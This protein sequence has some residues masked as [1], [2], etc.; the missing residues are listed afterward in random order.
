MIS[1][2][3][4]TTLAEALREYPG[5]VDFLVE[6]SP[7]YN[8]LKNT[9][10]RKLMAPRT[11]L[12]KVAQRGGLTFEELLTKLNAA[13]E[14]LKKGATQ[15]PQDDSEQVKEEIKSMIKQLKAGEDINTFKERFKDLLRKSNPLVIAVAEA[16]LTR[17]GYTIQDLMNACD[18]HLELF[19]ENLEKAKV[20]VP[21]EHPLWRLTRDHEAI[22]FWLNQGR[23][24]V[25]EMMKREGYHDSGDLVDKL[26]GIMAKLR[27]AENHDVRQENTLFPVLE[28][29]GVEEPAT[30]MWE[31]HS[32]MKDRRRE[33]GRILEAPP[34]G[35]D[36]RKYAEYLNGLFL[37]ILETFSKHSTKEQEILYQ[38]ALELLSEDDWKEIKEESDDL[39]YFE[40]PKEVLTSEY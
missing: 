2:K 39:G 5:L 31:E 14:E 12:A 25:K 17:E 23:D 9:T 11:S 26:K 32:Q 4:Q 35:W 20:R 16:E 24:V 18:I 22:L 3:K 19:R 37:F 15:G 6:F 10:I 29:Y 36:F 1:L 33:I 21:R 34:A 38:V 8:L 40:L 30:I 27:A 13:G 7:R 28:K